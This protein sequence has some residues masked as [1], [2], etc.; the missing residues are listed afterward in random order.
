[1]DHKEIIKSI[2]LSIK[3]ALDS[4]NQGDTDMGVAILQAAYDYTEPEE[5]KKDC[6]CG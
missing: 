5:L 6:G 4:I 2:R 3:E 1:M